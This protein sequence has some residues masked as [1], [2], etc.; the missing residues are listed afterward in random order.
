MY[1]RL[2]V[3]L[4]GSPQA[5]KALP[6]AVQLAKLFS[7]RLLLLHLCMEPEGSSDTG[8]S[9]SEN[10]LTPQRYLDQIKE[11]LTDPAKD[12]SLPPAQVQT[13]VHYDKFAYELGTVAAQEEIDLLIMTTHGRSGLS[14]VVMGSMATGVLKHTSQ[15]VLLLR[16]DATITASLEETFETFSLKPTQIMLPLD[17]SPKA[18]AALEPAIALATQLNISLHL[19]EVVTPPPPIIMPEPGLDYQL[20]AEIEQE[21]QAAQTQ[22][23]FHYLEKVREWLK[24][25]SPQLKVE[26]TVLK[27]SSIYQLVAFIGASKP[28]LVVMSTHARGE[29]GQ[30][31]LGSVAEEVLRQSH[32]PVLMVPISKGFEG[33]GLQAD[34]AEAKPEKKPLIMTRK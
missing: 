32:S 24:G 11:K 28:F 26:T 22:T 16:P 18:E 31:L 10:P 13:K 29:L 21:Q 2:A 30:L 14:L 8:Q 3:A 9:A 34:K 7:A 33:Y 17:G 15:P 1:T 6:L 20:I 19:V 12:W 5:E 27:G 23:A 25:K 4:D